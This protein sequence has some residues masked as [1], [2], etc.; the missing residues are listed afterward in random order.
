MEIEEPLNPLGPIASNSL[1]K[2]V[3]PSKPLRFKMD[4]NIKIILAIATIAVTEL[5]VYRNK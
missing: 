5:N 4:L 3:R 1:K 2:F